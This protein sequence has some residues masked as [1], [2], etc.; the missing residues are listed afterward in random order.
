MLTCFVD[1]SVDGVKSL[2]FDGLSFSA[3]MANDDT[4]GANS[5]RVNKGDLKNVTILL[6]SLILTEQPSLWQ[7]YPLKE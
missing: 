7:A 3:I 2:L 1:L 4:N 6:I 5:S